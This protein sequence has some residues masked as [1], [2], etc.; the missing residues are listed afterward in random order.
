M[1]IARSK[2]TVQAKAVGWRAGRRRVDIGAYS[3]EAEQHMRADP[4]EAELLSSRDGLGFGTPPGFVAFTVLDRLLRYT[5]QRRD[6]RLPAPIP[7]TYDVNE[8]KEAVAATAS[9]LRR[10]KIL[11]VRRR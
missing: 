9:G 11:I 6:G 5:E 3:P 4:E 10:G 8:I 7:V 2:G 1:E